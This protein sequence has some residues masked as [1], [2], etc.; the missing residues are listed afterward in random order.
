MH[1]VVM[2]RHGKAM[3]SASFPRGCVLLLS[4]LLALSGCGQQTSPDTIRVGVLE[5]GTVNWELATVQAHQLAAERGITLEI[6]PLASENALA[7]ALQGDRVDLI[8]SDWLWVARQRAAGH[9]FQFAPYSLTVGAVMVDPTAGI[10]TV[11]DLAGRKLGVAGGPVDKTWLLLRAYAKRK[12][13]LDLEQAATPKYAAPPILNKLM[14]RG[15]LPAAINYWHYNARLRAQGAAPLITVQK[16]LKAF[17]I[18]HAPPLL[19][20]VFKQAWASEHSEALKAFLDATYAAKALL[21]RSDDAWETLRDRV[22]PETEAVFAAII[23]GYRAGIPQAYGSAQIQA[24]R[25]LFDILAAEGGAT[26]LG[27][28]R[29]LPDDVFWNGFRLQ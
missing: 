17:G 9:L 29:H 23:A 27:P 6:V 13:G 20:W 16:M 26:L 12:Y 25:Q 19:G 24:A 11:A 21:A 2:G 8:V 1:S 22:K 7:V 5:Y 14:L 10:D 3:F 15:N 4:L 18:T 28:A